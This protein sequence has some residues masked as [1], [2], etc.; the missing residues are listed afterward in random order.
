[1]FEILRLQARG[2]LRDGMTEFILNDLLPWLRFF[3]LS[4]GD[5]VTDENMIRHFR[6]RL[7]E[8]GLIDYLV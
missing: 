5:R 2:N 7:T 1:M 6:N 8:N 4:L 3:G